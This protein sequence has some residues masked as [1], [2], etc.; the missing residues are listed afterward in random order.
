MKIVCERDKLLSSFQIAAEFAPGR[1][2]KEILQNVKLVASRDQVLLMGT[3]LEVGV[4]VTVQG[5]E[6]ETPGAAV[7]PVA[8]VG[9][10]LRENSDEKLTITAD[11]T[12][13]VV[14]GNRSVF[15]LPAADPDEFPN[16]ADFSEEKY[17]AISARLFREM[18]LRTEFATDLESTRYALGG[19]L[20]EFSPDQIT[21]VGTDGRRLARME[22]AAESIGGHKGS[23]GNT[24]IRT[25]SVRLIGRAMADA[26]EYVHICARSNDVLLR[27]PRAV[28]YS[29]LVEGRYPRWRDVIP[30]R[31]ESAKIEITVGPFHAALR[32]ASITCNNDSRGID[33]TFADGTLIFAGATADKGQSRVEM[34]I[35][36]TGAPIT[37]RLDHR[38]LSD[39]L[40]TLAAEQVVEIDIENGETATVF[41]AD[42]GRYAYVVMP[43]SRDSAG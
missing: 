2:P 30:Q 35:S 7:L 6:V 39:F 43:L 1:S 12:G 21:A 25:Q 37:V 36:Y 9:S 34:P 8:N 3:D 24:I 28:Y 4:R 14:K 20:F 26:D 27:T 10:I 15:K 5:V 41:R 33:A 17:H 19:V 16:V 13:I 23:D 38:Y 11:N 31:R 42:E 32:Q 40:K 29:R 22:G 18:V